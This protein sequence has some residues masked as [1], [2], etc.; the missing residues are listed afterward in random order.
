MFRIDGRYINSNKI[1]NF[2]QTSNN[3]YVSDKISN[4]FMI[5]I[6]I[7]LNY[8]KLSP[9]EKSKLKETIIQTLCID[10]GYSREDCLINVVRMIPDN[11][12]NLINSGFKMQV[13]IKTK[14]DVTGVTESQLI[15]KISNLNINNIDKN[16]GQ[17]YKDSNSNICVEDTCLT[18]EQLARLKNELKRYECLIPK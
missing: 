14:E 15:K 12:S 3:D 17:F 13:K 9:D 11:N 6:P 2:D 18:I 10:N 4:Y 16:I 7:A 1:E 8:D 5:E